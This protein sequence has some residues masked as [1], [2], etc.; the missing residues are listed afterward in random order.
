[1]RRRIS[2]SQSTNHYLSDRQQIQVRMPGTV[3][4]IP[5]FDKNQR[6]ATNQMQMQSIRFSIW[7]KSS[8][9]LCSLLRLKLLPTVKKR[10][11]TQ[12]TKE[13]KKQKGS[14]PREKSGIGG[15]SERTYVD[16][17]DII[18]PSQ[19]PRLCNR[20]QKEATINKVANIV[21]V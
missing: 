11:I 4:S 14:K 2:Q 12:G 3:R 15:T 7:D 5:I 9:L 10:N 21:R 20:R 1:M 17:S 6:K 18:S 13:R 19:P 16:N 8:I